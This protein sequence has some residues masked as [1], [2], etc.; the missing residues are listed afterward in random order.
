M[1][2]SLP[3]ETIRID[4]SS[5]D[6]AFALLSD[7]TRLAVL[8]ALWKASDSVAPTP[9]PFSEL[10]ER[11][12][13]KDPGRLNYHLN[14]LMTHFIRRTEDGYELREAGKRI[15]RV[16]IS[17]T[18][19]SDLSIEPVEVDAMCVFCDAPTELSYEDGWRYLY[20]TQCNAQCVDSYPDGVLSMHELP[21]SGVVHRTPNEI[22]EAD[23]IWAQHR[24]ASVIDGICPDCAGPMPVTALRTCENHVPSPD[25]DEVCE[26]CGSIFWTEVINTC[27]ICTSV[28]KMP[29][30]FHLS[31]HP[32][33]VA[34][35]YDHGIEFHLASYEH[36]AYFLTYQEELVSEDPL[37]IRTTIPLEGDELH[38]TVDGEMNVVDV[39]G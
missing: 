33:V 13:V 37:R 18:A 21:P 15:V 23:R 1:N 25:Y 31:T 10:R 29:V 28:W 3:S 27:E 11:V 30:P 12:G 36:R 38:V 6:E 32:A 8:Q 22:H 4:D 16:L 34:F 5:A 20:C 9:V 35:Y 39:S 7:S 19:V 2:E 26:N 14:K 17:G 24:R